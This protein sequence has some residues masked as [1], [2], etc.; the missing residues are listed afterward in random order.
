MDNLNAPH[1]KFEIGR[2]EVAD[3]A[4]NRITRFENC[5]L[6]ISLEIRCKLNK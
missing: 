3:A 4:P 1:E 6:K 2:S 5:K